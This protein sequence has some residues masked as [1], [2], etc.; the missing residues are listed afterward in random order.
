MAN[1]VFY[2]L[3][4]A[5][6]LNFS[7]GCINFS[8]VNRTFLGVYRSIFESSAQ[9]ID[10]YGNP[11]APFYKKDVLERLLKEYF[12]LNLPR[13]VTSYKTRIYYYNSDSDK[14]ICT[15]NYCTNVDIALNCKINLFFD[16]K[17]SQSFSLVVTGL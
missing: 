17:R 4:F 11:V 3:I 14:T 12:D 1:F 8:G 15:S 2:V 6:F 7:T 5:F 9:T 16:Y 10:D 13:Y